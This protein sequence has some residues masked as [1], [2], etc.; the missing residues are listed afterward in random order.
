[1]KNLTKIFMAVSVALFA[2]A[3]A[4]DP[5]ED[6]G[7]NVGSSVDEVTLTLSLEETKTQL[8]DKAGS[9]YPLYWS[10]GDK[11]SVNGVESNELSKAQAGS[12]AA[13]FKVNT[14]T[15]YR[16]TYPAVAA[17]NKVFFAQ[18][19]QHT[20]NTTFG[21]GVT[22]MYAYSEDGNDI[23]LHHLTGV[24]KIGVVG[25]KTLTLA[26][27]STID[28]APIAGSFDFDFEKG[29]AT[30]NDSSE[31]VISYSFGD[32]VALSSTPTVMHIAVPAGVY[33]ELYVTLYDNEGGVMYATVKASEDDP[34]TSKEERPLSAGMV[35]EFSTN[36]TYTPNDKVFVVHD[37]ESLENFAS[38]IGSLG[39]DVLF[40][41]DV[42]IPEG[43]T[44][45]SIDN[46][47]YTK[48][49]IGNGYAIKGLNAPL[50]DRVGATIESLHLEDVEFTETT[51]P[52]V[53]AFARYSVGANFKNCSANGTITIN[54]TT[55]KDTT[56]KKYNQVLVGG[57][58][59]KAKGGS[60]IDCTNHVNLNIISLS[61]PTIQHCRAVGGVVGMV[62]TSAILSGITNYGTINFEPTATVAGPITIAGV[63]GREYEATSLAK[64][65]N[66]TNYGTLNIEANN[67]GNI[68]IG[69]ITQLIAHVYP[70]GDGDHTIFNNLKN[71]GNINISGTAVGVNVGGVTSYEVNAFHSGAENSGNITIEGTYSGNMTI[72]G[73]HRVVNAKTN[74]VENTNLNT[75]L[76]FE[77]MSNSGNITIKN[78]TST[79]GELQIG[80][81]IGS[82]EA[83]S[84]NAYL[85][86]NYA[87]ISNSGSISVGAVTISKNVTVGGLWHSNKVGFNIKNCEN[88]ST[89]TISLTGTTITGYCR[90]GGMFGYQSVINYGNNSRE[91]TDCSNNAAL[92]VAVAS[93]ASVQLGGIV[94]YGDTKRNG[95]TLK[96]IRTNNS[97][98]INLGGENYTC[99]EESITGTIGENGQTAVA[100]A[101]A[102]GG[103]IGLLFD[104]NTIDDCKN[105]G[106]LTVNLTGTASH[107]TVGGIIGRLMHHTS[108]TTTITSTTNEGNIDYQPAS[109]T[110]R[111]KLGG[112]IG[113]SESFAG[114]TA[115]GTAVSPWE[116]INLTSCNNSGAIS[117]NSTSDISQLYIGGLIADARC[118]LVNISD[119]HSTN[120]KQ[121]QGFTLSSNASYVY[122]GLIGMYI[123]K[124]K[125]KTS[126]ITGCSSSSDLTF[127]KN[128]TNT[129]VYT[130]HIVGYNTNPSTADE[131][132]VGTLNI[133]NCD[134]SS[135]F[136]YHG[137]TT[138]SFYYGGYY[139]YP[140]HANLTVNIS[141]CTRSGEV[142]IDGET[143][144]RTTIGGYVGY[145]RSEVN[146]TNVENSANIKYA[147]VKS[148][149]DNHLSIGGISST[150]NCNSKPTFEHVVNK[151]S[152]T[153]CGT[154]KGILYVGGV[155]SYNANRIVNYNDTHNQGHI[156]LGTTEKALNAEQLV[157]VGGVVG[158]S[159]ETNG[160]VVTAPITNTGDIAM[161]N[162]S[163]IGDIENSHIGG[164]IGSTIAPI[165]GARCFCNITAFNDVKVGFITGTPYSDAIKSTNCHIGG[166]IATTIDAVANKP[167]WTELDDYNYVEHI[168]GGG[169][170]VSDE[171]A[172]EN[173]L[174]WLKENINDTPI[175]IDGNP[176]VSE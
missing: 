61:D 126:T 145:W 47:A 95:H 127:A 3:C 42:V 85:K 77:N 94:G 30:A 148:G 83:N 78:G 38:N 154:S 71:R 35:R 104:Y 49:I 92:N 8:G 172:I 25:N 134:V 36:I 76:L 15:P 160:V 54:N 99:T 34:E 120:N 140:N 70:A 163:T 20:S 135:N 48:R 50:F 128:V 142:L 176:I 41:N 158:C 64:F 132:L 69:G 44:W 9:L 39:K 112:I 105:T 162:K 125:D 88:S 66:C 29:V 37:Y 108:N 113:Y 129:A 10:E 130:S 90:V 170:V 109:I 65:S 60:I 124:V 146:F 153:V 68:Y 1:M 59:G 116:T 16:I 84:R 12:K 149:S 161:S 137:K 114:A 165:S 118:L 91:V 45:T 117:I 21:S 11:I 6:L 87:N 139:G 75:N 40:V 63:L 51:D 62:W 93:A 22:T 166:K 119:C 169:V 2:F 72:G 55:F 74:E 46:Y 98:A 14:T 26:Q 82:G 111:S 122:A 56:T 167:N 89:G 121:K 157:K 143:G 138:G 174:G 96:Y 79:T 123:H 131:V 31:D 152:I 106:N 86:T 107:C 23:E 151:G 102:V 103:I 52:E 101:N 100:T 33:N 58:I 115:G 73:V 159:D 141:N 136:N 171:D 110:G 147:G 43:K 173:K 164:I 80:G 168:Y 81:V 17:D 13:E 4:T 133:S 7:S 97:G 32:G 155:S 28:R 175:C 156:Y 24:L 57:L 144:G 18:Q 53:G 67:S 150:S 5:T 19:Q 27:I